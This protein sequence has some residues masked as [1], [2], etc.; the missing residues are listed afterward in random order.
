FGQKDYRIVRINKFTLDVIPE[1]NMIVLY[2]Y[3]KPG[4]IGNIGTTLGASNV[5]IARLHLSRQQVD[6]QALVV[7]TTDGTVPEEVIQRLRDLP[8]VISVNQLE[9]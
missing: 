5:N 9:L 6:G 4:V 8:N 3:D 7:L 2:N 1:G